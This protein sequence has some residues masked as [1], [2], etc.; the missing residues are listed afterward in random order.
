MHPG[1]LRRARPRAVG[2]WQSIFG[3]VSVIFL[4]RIACSMKG[5]ATFANDKND[6]SVKK[7]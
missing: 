6:I 3:R 2:D 1:R 7:K 5:M 4:M